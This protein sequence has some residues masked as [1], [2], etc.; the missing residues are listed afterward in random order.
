MEKLKAY[1]WGSDRGALTGID[2]RVVAAR[3]DKAKLAELEQALLG[4]LQSDAKLPA[5]EYVCRQ[6]ALIGTSRSVPALAAMLPDPELSDRARLALAVI[7]DA[8]AGRALRRALGKAEGD[9][10]VGIV[11]TLGER[12]DKKAVRALKKMRKGPDPV[13]A[14]AAEAAL[15]KIAPPVSR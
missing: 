4:V 13:L 3:G 7:P 5:K 8:S 12:G 10:R 6:L 9:P 2:D 1:D 14:K 11:N 15:R